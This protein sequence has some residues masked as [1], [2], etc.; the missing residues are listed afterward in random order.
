M[1][2]RIT[3]AGV[4]LTVGI[5]VLTAVVLGGLYLIQQRGEQARRDEAIKIAEQ[6]L[7]SQSNGEVALNEGESSANENESENGTGNGAENGE[8]ATT[9]EAASTNTESSTSAS[10]TGATSN[11]NV[12][13]AGTQLPQTGPA[14]SLMAAV[15]LGVGTFTALSFVRSRKLLPSRD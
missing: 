15:L 9:N 10:E 4:G 2:I 13:T 7:E 14:E 8:A 5:I 1:A 11:G 12:P 6:N 3:R